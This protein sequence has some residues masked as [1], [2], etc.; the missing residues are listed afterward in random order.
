ME[1]RVGCG[2]LTRGGGGGGG[3]KR[4][5][6]RSLSVYQ[7][8]EPSRFHLS[9]AQSAPSERPPYQPSVLASLCT[10]LYLWLAHWAAISSCCWQQHQ[11]TCQGWEL[12][13]CYQDKRFFFFVCCF[14]P[15]TLFCVF[16]LFDNEGSHKN[17][18]RFGQTHLKHNKWSHMQ[19]RLYLIFLLF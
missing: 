17:I 15:R 19:C 16:M 11:K 1:S 18:V 10:L 13:R 9:V 8:A 5:W 4:R 2:S 7:W 6:W 12:T 14:L 3:W